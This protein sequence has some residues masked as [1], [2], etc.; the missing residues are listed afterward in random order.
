MLQ[1]KANEDV[2]IDDNVDM[3]K[4][5][6]KLNVD[7]ELTVIDNGASHAFLNLKCACGEN[8]S[9]YEQVLSILRNIIKLSK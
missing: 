8:K 2:F 1:N 3:A 6:R 9:A 7:H 4:L 5:F